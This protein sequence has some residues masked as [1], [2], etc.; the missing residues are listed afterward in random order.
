[1]ALLLMGGL[2]GVG[3]AEPSYVGTEN[4][5]YENT[6]L[7]YLTAPSLS[8][9][10]ILRPS[11]LFALPTLGPK[12]SE[13]IDFDFHWANIW[14][15]TPDQYMI[16]GEWIRSTLR[17]SYAVKDYLSLGVALP[18]IGRTGGI[19]DSSIEDFHKAFHLGK[20]DRNQ[21]PQNRSLVTVTDHG[22]VDTV[23]EGESWGIGDVSAFA[24]SRLT[25]GTRV[26]P[27]VTVQGEVF[28][29]T[30]NEDELRGM[31]V[32]S[33]AAS[34]VMS[35]RLWAS[36]F[37]SYLGFGIHYCDAENI[38]KIHVRD[39]QMSALAGLEYQ[40]SKS[41]GFMF[42]YL[43]SSPLAMN[44]LAL[45]KPTHEVSGG[46]KW[47]VGRYSSLEVSVVENIIVFQNSAD[48]GINLAY[49]RRL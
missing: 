33:V 3:H 12:G 22:T 6:G 43:L 7:G 20:A 32:P 5:S 1:M 23:V 35:K 24:V 14:N 10:H 40:H 34:S 8:P 27:A 38:A 30:G 49:G 21:F 29:P 2:S 16:D 47:R 15:Y 46:F 39:E 42:Q 28:L 41:L 45:A 36:P 17:Y 11:S 18:F 31:G 37:I 48:I 9:G 19:A 26:W 4:S 44:Y 13:Q 25:E